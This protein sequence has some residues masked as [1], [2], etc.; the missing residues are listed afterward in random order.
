[1]EILKIFFVLFYISCFII[2]SFREIKLFDFFIKKKFIN[3][4]DSTMFFCTWRLFINLGAASNDIRI[5]VVSKNRTLIWSLRSGEKIGNINIKSDFSRVTLCY[6]WDNTLF[7]S[8]FNEYFFEDMKDF[9][10]KQSDELI[11]FKIEKIYYDSITLKEYLPKDG[12]PNPSTK[13]FE[14][15]KEDEYFSFN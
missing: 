8:Q 12:E 11:L 6:H 10:S 4:L 3:F 14:W 5:L 13:L 7:N 15:K 2:V 1:M 9:L